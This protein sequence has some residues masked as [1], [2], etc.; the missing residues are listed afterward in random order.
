MLKTEAKHLKI[1]KTILANYPYKFYA[2]GS[3][4]S[5]EPRKLSDLDLCFFDDIPFNVRAH[6]EEDFEQSDLPYK[7]DLVDFNLTD[8]SFKEKIKSDLIVISEPK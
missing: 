5:G 2:F 8:Q 1:I 4:V 3:R 6:I 7:V